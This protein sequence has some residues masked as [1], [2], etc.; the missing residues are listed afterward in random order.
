MTTFDRQN[1]H[2]EHGGG[3]LWVMREL[4]RYTMFYLSVCILPTFHCLCFVFVTFHISFS[5]SFQM[6]GRSFLIQTSTTNTAHL[7]SP[8]LTLVYCVY[9]HQVCYPSFVFLCFSPMQ[10]KLLPSTPHTFTHICSLWCT[11]FTHISCPWVVSSTFSPLGM[12]INLE[13]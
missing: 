9:T 1:W 10:S 4:L 12:W 3:W 13:L 11:A 8:L 5:S 2:F 6:G 7:H